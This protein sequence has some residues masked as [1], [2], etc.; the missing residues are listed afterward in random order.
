[1]NKAMKIFITVCFFAIVITG[2]YVKENSEEIV[3]EVPCV[4][5]SNNINLDGIMCQKVS[6]EFMGSS[7]IYHFAI[8]NGIYGLLGLF[9]MLIY[10]L[11]G[12]LE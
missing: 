5:G 10:L 12:C 11:L 1:M 3:K 2:C 9:S 7:F 4:D 6:H 8:L